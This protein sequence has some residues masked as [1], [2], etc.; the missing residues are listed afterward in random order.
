MRRG[1]LD[2]KAPRGADSRYTTERIRS[3]IGGATGAPRFVTVGRGC[4]DTRGFRKST[5]PLIAPFLAASG[6]VTRDTKVTKDTKGTVRAPSIVVNLDTILCVL[7]PPLCPSSNAR[8]R[9]PRERVRTKTQSA[10]RPG[11]HAVRA[12]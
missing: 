8:R 2:S 5:R 12:G 4:A 10:W 6:R 11:S 7:R 3:A 9:Y 1:S